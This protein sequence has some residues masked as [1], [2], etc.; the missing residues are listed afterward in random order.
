MQSEKMS[1]QI[2]D[3][4]GFG[5]S[6]ECYIVKKN[7]FYYIQLRDKELGICS[8]CGERHNL[9]AH[10]VIPRRLKSKNP[11]LNEL[12]LKI[13]YHCHL[14]IDSSSKYIL[15]CK[16]LSQMLI[17][18]TGGEIQNVKAYQEIQEELK[19]V[20]L[21]SFPV[22]VDWKNQKLTMPKGE[23]DKRDSDEALARQRA[24]KSK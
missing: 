6:Q 18:A 4:N 10:H 15:A 11:I 17:D 19:N 1:W 13:C 20:R 2:K 16:K 8:V 22:G 7:Q 3:H 24:C 21:G 5:V 9:S 23:G 14:E 12:R